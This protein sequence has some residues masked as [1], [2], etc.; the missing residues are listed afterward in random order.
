MIGRYFENTWQ[1]IK[2]IE[3]NS[4]Q[5]CPVKII[6]GLKALSQAIHAPFQDLR[7]RRRCLPNQR[8]PA[9]PEK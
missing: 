3:L 6:F 5:D 9:K 8:H 1:S 4:N 2:I 7:I